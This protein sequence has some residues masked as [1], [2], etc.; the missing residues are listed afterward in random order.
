VHSLEKLND[1]SEFPPKIVNIR[2]YWAITGWSGDW[3]KLSPAIARYL[4]VRKQIKTGKINE[5]RTTGH[6][7]VSWVSS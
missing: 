1:W 6:D 2:Y 4:P 3:I 7:E 5:R